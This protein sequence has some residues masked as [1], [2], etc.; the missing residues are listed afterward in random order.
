MVVSEYTTP[1][2][3][4]DGSRLFIGIKEQ[5]PEI[6][7][8][9]SIKANV[10]VWHYKDVVPQAVQIVQIAQTRRATYPGRRIRGHGQVR[11]TGRRDDAHRHERGEQHDRRR[12]ERHGVSR[13]DRLGR[14][15]SRLYKVDLNTGARTLIDKGLSRTYGTSPDS[16]WFLYLKNKQVIAYNL[17]TGKAVTLDASTIPGKSYVER[18]RR[19]R[20]R[21]A[22]LGRRRMDARRKVGAAL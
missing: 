6:P 9:D 21:E 19:P 11:A 1:R 20:V 15:P 10:D 13:R 16:K 14:E 8:A 2:W 22:D 3:S 17:E 12:P 5:E 4:P 7:A 18:G